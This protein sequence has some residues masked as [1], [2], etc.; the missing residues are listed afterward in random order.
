MRTEYTLQDVLDRYSEVFRDELGTVRGTAAKIQLEP[1]TQ[2]V[3]QKARPVPFA[4]RKKVEA[5]LE[6]LK[7]L[8]IRMNEE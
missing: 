3:F 8:G 1:G 6:R 5:E 7:Q 4:L 2:P